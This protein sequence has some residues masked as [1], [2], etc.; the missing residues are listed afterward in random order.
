MHAR[1][2]GLDTK[3]PELERDL[4]LMRQRRAALERPGGLSAWLRLRRRS[5]PGSGAGRG[6]G[7]A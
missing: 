4:R 6:P 2:A 3:R 7:A 1:P 5:P